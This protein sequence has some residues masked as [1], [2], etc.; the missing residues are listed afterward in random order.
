VG[1]LRRAGHDRAA[2]PCGGLARPAGVFSGSSPSTLGSSVWSSPRFASATASAAIA[3]HKGRFVGGWFLFG[4]LLGIVA[5][6]AVLLLPSCNP[7][8]EACRKPLDPD[9]RLCP[10]C[11]T[12]RDLVLQA[13]DRTG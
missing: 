12:E 1:A 5:L 10:W 9:A 11:W 13:V 3:D 2:L 8:C 7:R 6:P 4:A